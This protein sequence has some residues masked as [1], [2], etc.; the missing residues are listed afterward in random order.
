MTKFILP[1]R[2]KADK[3]KGRKT[4]GR[5]GEQESLRARELEKKQN[6]SQLLFTTEGTKGHQ[7]ILTGGLQHQIQR[8]VLKL[9]R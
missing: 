4:E 3:G 5:G 8:Q 6:P 9:I 2:R 1:Q 7:K